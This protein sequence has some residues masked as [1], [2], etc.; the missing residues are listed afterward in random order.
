MTPSAAGAF[1]SLEGGEG[2]G[3]STQAK[4]LAAQLAKGGRTVIVTREPGG[5]PRAETLRDVILSGRVKRFGAFAETVLFAAARASHLGATIRPA[6]DRGEWVISDRFTDSTRVYQGALGKVDERLIRALE[7]IVVGPTLPELTIILDIPADVGLQ[8]A[9]FRGKR[10][11]RFEREDLQF[12]M[13]L[14]DGFREIAAREPERCVLIDA[15]PQA[16]TV[17]KAIWNAVVR[18]FALS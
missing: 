6:L 3:K 12:H 9:A 7:R 16:E 2:A 13:R 15:E 1:I 5:S 10:P 14:R 4:R 17:S 18:R 8:R 11:D